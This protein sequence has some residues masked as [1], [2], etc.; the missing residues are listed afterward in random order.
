MGNCC[1]VHIWSMHSDSLHEIYLSGWTMGAHNAYAVM[2]WYL[3][4]WITSLCYR[5]RLLCK[6]HRWD[7]TFHRKPAS[8]EHLRNHYHFSGSACLATDSLIFTLTGEPG[9]FRCKHN[10]TQAITS[11]H[12]DHRKPRYASFIESSKLKAQHHFCGGGSLSTF[13]RKIILT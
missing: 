10:N 3:R 13:N 4:R 1:E 9:R 12:K 8:S 6:C 7:L 11:S 5:A 2:R